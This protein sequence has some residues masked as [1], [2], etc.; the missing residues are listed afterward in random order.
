MSGQRQ[1]VPAVPDRFGYVTLDRGGR[2]VTRSRSSFPFAVRRVVADRRVRDDR[3]RMAIERG[4]IVYCAEWPDCAGGHVLELL[5]DPEAH[6]A[7]SRPRT[8]RRR[9]GDQHGSPQPHQPG[10]PAEPIRLIPYYLWANRGA[11]EMTVWLLDRGACA[12]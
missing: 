7:G 10:A 2:P 8:V 11:G 4:P 3:G 9:H 12:R 6:D 5:V 1:A